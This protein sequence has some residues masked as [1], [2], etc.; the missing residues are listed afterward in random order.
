MPSTPIQG[1]LRLADTVAP[2]PFIP[3]TAA[4]VPL[5]RLRGGRTPILPEACLVPDCIVCAWRQAGLIPAVPR[6]GAVR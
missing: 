6:E 2:D 1:E 5:L 3:D 4:P